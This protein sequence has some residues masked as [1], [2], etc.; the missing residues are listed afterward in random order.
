MIERGLQMNNISIIGTG[1]VGLVSGACLSDFGMH[2]TCVDNNIKKVNDLK[3][4]LIPIYEPGLDELVKRNTY[5]KRLNF[6]TDI[7]TAIETNEV[8]FIAV[9]TPPKDDGSADL[10]YVLSVA[11]DISKYMNGY[12]IIVDKSTVPVGTGKLVKKV[13]KEGLKK[14]NINYNF[15]IVSNPEFLREGAAIRDFTHPDRIIIGAESEKAIEVMKEVYRVLYLNET[16]FIITNIETA[17]LIKYASNAFLATKISF[18]NELTEL[19]EK[20]G[21]DIQ[22]ISKGMGMDG[23][24]GPKFLHAGPGYGGS[25]FPKDTKA[26]LKIGQ[27]YGCNLSIIKSTIEA[28]TAQKLRLVKKVNEY[29]GN[30]EGKTIAVLGLAFKPETDDMRESPALTIIFELYKLG[31]NFRLY[32]PQAFKEAKWRFESINNKIIYCDDEY[33]AVKN[34]DAVIIL[35]EWNQFR[36]LNLNRMKENMKSNYFFD[37]RNIYDGDKVI[38]AGFNY[39]CIGKV[40]KLK[41]DKIEVEEEVTTNIKR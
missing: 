8:I 14:R 39:Y 36:N 18:I 34:A 30:L 15:D 11:E 28:N 9:G 16:P 21:A 13:I 32:D 23:R 12:K 37:F 20:V 10:Q 6:T 19:C 24:I 22:H 35:T 4:G 40:Y 27:K 29:M 25:C 17:E 5:Y 33:E 38:K 31:A 3:T 1:Y 41:N 26:L 7:K 2:V